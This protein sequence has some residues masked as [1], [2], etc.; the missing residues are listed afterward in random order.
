MP[1]ALQLYDVVLSVH[2]MAIVIAF[3]AWFAYP[4][5]VQQRDAAAHRAQVRIARRVVTPAATVALIAGAYLATDRDY[6]SESWVSIPLLILLVLLG[7][8]GAYFTRRQE[9]LAELAAA[10]AAETGAAEAEYAQLAAKV[11]RMYLVCMAL[12]LVAVFFMVA[13]PFS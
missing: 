11:A 8:N 2:V 5:L 9:R 10:R 6:W 13:K 3:G 1:I 4:L 12:V 7:L